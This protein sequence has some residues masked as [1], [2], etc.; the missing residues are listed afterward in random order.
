MPTRGDRGTRGYAPA[1][2]IICHSP[3]IQVLIEDPSEDLTTVPTT[4]SKVDPERVL[5]SPVRGWVCRLEEGDLRDIA[6]VGFHPLHPERLASGMI[7]L[8]SDVDPER[9]TDAG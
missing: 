9:I 7:V 1:N 2:S 6:C 4:A 5:S 8:G 3:R